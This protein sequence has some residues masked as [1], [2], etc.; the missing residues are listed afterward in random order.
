MKD[1]YK[2][3][4]IVKHILTE[5]PET[6]ADNFLLISEV[7]SYIDSRVDDPL[8]PL[9]FTQLM[10]N[11]AHYNLPSFESITRARRKLQAEN[12]DLQPDVE[13]R[14]MRVNLKKPYM[15]YALD[16]KVSKINEK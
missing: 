8:F 1:L 2:V 15:E 12:E 14:R 9:S 10:K 13:V 7:Y 4:E 5:Q 3:E 11:H 16:K 6:R